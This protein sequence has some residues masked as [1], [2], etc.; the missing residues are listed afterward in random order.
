LPS[1]WE[2]FFLHPHNYAGTVL[3]IG[4]GGPGLHV[5]PFRH[6]RLRRLERKHT[7]S[8]I[9]TKPTSNRNIGSGT[10][11]IVSESV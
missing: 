2:T 5:P 3:P 7:L 1:N 4:S 6:G 11:D 8:P 9:I 10:A